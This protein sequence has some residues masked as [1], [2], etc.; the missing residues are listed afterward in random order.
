MWALAFPRNSE[1][2]PLG[3]LYAQHCHAVIRYR[4]GAVT[5][6]SARVTDHL[7]QP[8]TSLPAYQIELLVSSLK[9]IFGEFDDAMLKT[10]T[11]LL[12]WVELAGGQTL[13]R[14]GDLGDDL[15][16]VISGR[17]RAYV[18]N[19]VGEP[20]LIGEIMRGQTIGEMALFTQEPRSATV[21]TIRDSVLVRM[22]RPFFEQLLSVYPLVS[23]SMIRLI[24]ERLKRSNHPRFSIRRPVNIC[25]LP[26]TQGWMQT[27]WAHN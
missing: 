10:V 2:Y 12:E 6:D 11:P 26:I 23:L 27:S 1:A 3:W 13:L 4:H 5:G 15:Y 21:I 17:L 22:T 25:L 14:E 8:C 18:R 7:G 24:I 9:Q 20:S 19:D 16:F